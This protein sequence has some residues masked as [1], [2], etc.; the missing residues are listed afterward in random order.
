MIAAAR[1]AL[2]AL[3]C[4]GA[5]LGQAQQQDLPELGDPTGAISEYQSLINS[6][7]AIIKDRAA[8]LLEAAQTK[9]EPLVAKP[10]PPPVQPEAPK[11]EA[12]AAPVAPAP[13]NK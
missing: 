9:L 7:N 8:A 12:P 10:T 13:D 5:G 4:L 6:T 11:P 1:F 3:L 2:V